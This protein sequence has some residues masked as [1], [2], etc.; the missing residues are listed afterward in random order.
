[1]QIVQYTKEYF[2]RVQ[3]IN[4]ISVVLHLNN[5]ENYFELVSITLF[6]EREKEKLKGVCQL[7]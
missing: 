7:N 3:L 1:M 5:K 4:E 2:T 6:A